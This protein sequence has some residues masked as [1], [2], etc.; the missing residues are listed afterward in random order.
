ML[1]DLLRQHIAI[2]IFMQFVRRRLV[3]LFENLVESGGVR[4]FV[5]EVVAVDFSQG[6]DA[7]IA[8]FPAD[9][10]ILVAVAVR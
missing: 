2:M 8:V 1:S 6:A 7:R 9:L 5:R 10:A 4:K 3:E